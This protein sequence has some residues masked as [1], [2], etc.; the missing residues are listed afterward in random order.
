MPK[1]HQRLRRD[2]DRFRP[3][4][5]LLEERLPPG[6]AL[7]GMLWGLAGADLGLAEL[8]FDPGTAQAARLRLTDGADDPADALATPIRTK[9]QLRSAAAPD[10]PA[11]AGNSGVSDLSSAPATGASAGA[12]PSG[13][14]AAAPIA[15]PGLAVGAAAR[16][17]GGEPGAV[18]P[19]GRTAVAA[20]LATP[21]ARSGSPAAAPSAQRAYGQLPLSFEANMGQTASRVNFIAHAGDATVFLTPTAA[22]FAMQKRSAVSGQQSAGWPGTSPQVRTTNAGVALYMDLVGAN[23]AGRAAGVNPLPG[24]VNYFIGNDPAKWHTDIPTFGR[25]EYPDVY[26]GVSLA[27]YGGPGGLEY[28]LVLSPGADPHAIALKFEGADGVWLNAQGDLVVHTDAGDLVQH[29]PVLYQDVGGQRQAVAGRFTLDSGLVRF[30]VGAYDPSR[31]L[32]IDP[33]V[34]GYSTYLGGSGTEYG[35]GIAVDGKGAAYVVGE[36]YSSNFP[37]TPGAFDTSYNGGYN[38]GDAFV[39]K[40]STDAH[41]LVYG[42]YLGGSGDDEGNG[43]A[44]DGSGYAYVTG[45]G[46]SSNFPITIHFG[47]GKNY[48]AFLTKL[49]PTGSGL[50][51]SATIA[52]S[53]GEAIAV[54][55]AGEAMATGRAGPGFP[56]TPGAFQTGYGGPPSGSG[57]VFVAKMNPSGT[58]LAYA[59]LLGGWGFDD[60]Y[61]IAADAAGHAYVTG[62]TGSGNFPTTPGAYQT[63][64]PNEENGFLVKLSADGSTLDYGTFLGAGSDRAYG[65]ALDAAGNA[66]VSGNGG[67][68]L[69]VT[70]TF[71]TGKYGVYIMK[72]NPAGSALVYCALI[73][74][75]ALGPLG[76]AVDAAGGAYLAGSIENGGLQT[77]SD[78][79]DQTYNGGGP[80]YHSDAIMVEISPDGNTLVYSTYLG[81]S[82]DDYGHAI[83]VD[84]GGNVYMTGET[85]SPDF[86]T[87]A[88]A[89]KRR[90]RNGMYDAFVTKFALA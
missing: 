55:P 34:L 75:A 80:Q 59:T 32:V 51:Y 45:R 3:Q 54:D 27:Y 35:R 74:N 68:P 60:G 64:Y 19:R 16:R 28:D 44:V 13:V 90:N 49:T 14:S 30:D 52:D 79:F 71:G 58:A 2:T 12:V 20:A 37:A 8:G 87:S 29:T 9:S 40:L 77:T 18:L 89:F 57:D 31:P 33:L 63:T 1:G 67:T 66:Y 61:G 73:A 10:R 26:A 4:L 46:D 38:Y 72:M 85:Q 83:A 65:V 36:T 17:M 84:A 25:V 15:I 7:V 47:A 70:V 88:D 76:V 82:N 22:V 5:V 48:G 41:S 39:A 43:I 81:G 53:I 6:D 86:P 69:P 50:V 62:Y 24:K 11:P 56:V 21:P 42:T 78:A 23:P